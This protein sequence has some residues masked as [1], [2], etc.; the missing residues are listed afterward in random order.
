MKGAIGVLKKLKI[1]SYLS[2][3]LILISVLTGCGT[4]YLWGNRNEKW[5]KDLNYLKKALPAKHVNL[6]FQLSEDEFNSDIED[7]KSNLSS[8]SDEEIENGIYKIMAKLGNG[9]T[10]AKVD[11]DYRFPV[12]FYNFDGD[13]YLINTSEEYSK[14]LYCKLK[15]IDGMKADE[16]INRLKLLVTQ[17]NEA[18]IKSKVPTF[19]VRPDTLKGA[20]IIN[21]EN[22][23]VFTFEDSSGNDFDL[24]IKS[25]LNSNMKNCMILDDAKDESNPLYR[26]HWDSNFWYKYTED[27]RILY[28]KYNASFENKE[29]G[30]IS[31]SIN[32]MIQYI[33]DDKVDKFVIDMRNNSGGRDGQISEL[34]DYIK[35][36]SINSPDKF[37]VI[38]GRQTFS[39]SI[40]DSCIIRQETNAT[41]L[42]EPTQGKP[43]HYG[44]ESKFVLPNNK[45]Y[46]YYSTKFIDM[47]DDYSDSFMPDKNIVVSLE[48]Y[49][50]KKDPIMDYIL[51]K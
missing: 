5:E 50:N 43:R 45:V 28:F 38:V 1:I 42:G 37:F 11:Y 12:N 29:T 34:I 35:D 33:D 6:F 10:V 3:F 23:A 36:S 48:D 15:S 13:L 4:Q 7:L 41:F 14:A 8:M 40:V 20:G 24:E 2:V 9:H 16:I 32:E 18:I 26:Q 27:N 21:N 22:S 17:C 30:K 19:L 25:V 46:I 44:E 31:E 51:N 39:A 49:K 47:F